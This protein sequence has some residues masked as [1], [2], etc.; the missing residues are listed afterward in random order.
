MSQDARLD[1]EQST[2]RRARVLGMN[3]VDTSRLE[4]KTLYELLTVQELYETKVI[5]LRQEKGSLLF[6]VTTT[7]SQQTM[8]ALTQRFADY[9]VDFA[10]I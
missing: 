7:T 10:I 8:S 3:Y 4:P 6:G 2:Q 9:R 5:P 1:E